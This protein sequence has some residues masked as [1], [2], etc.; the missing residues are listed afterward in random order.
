MRNISFVGKILD[1]DTHSNLRSYTA[2][3]LMCVQETY[4]P[5]QHHAG[6]PFNRL[7]NSPRYPASN[8]CD[9]KAF[10]TI[11]GMSWCTRLRRFVSAG[12]AQV[13]L[14]FKRPRRGFE[15]VVRP[16]QAMA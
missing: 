6:S 2:K 5:R 14:I 8:E 3:G 16:D 11:V 9:H 13:M 7:P 4:A 10:F 1:L 12:Y 15:R